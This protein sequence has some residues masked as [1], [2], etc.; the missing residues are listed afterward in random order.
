MIIIFIIFILILIY[1][2]KL[3]KKFSIYIYI[4]YQ[5]INTYIIFNIL[6]FSKKNTIIHLKN[7]LDLYLRKNYSKIIIIINRQINYFYK[8]KYLSLK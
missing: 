2:D 4:I 8:I 1:Y 6:K 3:Q 7:R 5:F